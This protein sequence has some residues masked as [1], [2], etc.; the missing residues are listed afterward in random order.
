MDRRRFLY[1]S[2]GFAA[3]AAR[4]GGS[5]ILSPVAGNGG[6][7]E[8]LL[9]MYVHEGWPYNHPYAARTWTVEDW[10]G[11][12]DGLSKLGYNMVVMWPALE[13]MPEPLMPSDRAQIEKTANVIG[14][15]RRDFG[16]RVFLTLC[17]N[18]IANERVARR[19]S[20][21]RRPLFSSVEFVDPSNV[22][23]MKRMIAWRE[24]LLRP[25]SQMDGIAIIDSDPGGFPGS[26][27]S[28]FAS[29]LEQHRHMLDRLRP[30]ID[31][32]YWMHVGWEAYCDYY[33]TGR[34]RWGTPLEAE[35]VLKKIKSYDPQPW[36]I[37]IHTLNP[38]PNGTDLNLAKR[39]GLATTA[40]AFNYGAIEGE[41]E[42]PLTNFGG[43]A[44]FKAGEARAPLGVVGN[45]QT[46]CVQL[47]NTFA[48][49]RGAK[50]HPISAHDYVQFADGLIEGKAG[51]VVSAWRAIEGSDSKQM[52]VIAADLD[53]IRDAAL[54]PGNLSGLLFGNPH[55]FLSDL[56]FQ[57]RMKA[58]FVDFVGASQETIDYEKFRLFVAATAAWQKRNGFQ[59]AW[60]SIWS[61][62]WKGLAETLKKL[63][64]PSLDRILA[65]SSPDNGNWNITSYVAP[66][67]TPFERVQNLYHEWDTNGF[68]LIAEM[69]KIS[70]RTGPR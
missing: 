46:H 6:T 55:R 52:R 40:L 30:G 66:G 60:P 8:G 61:E 14:V 12:A 38:P 35:D 13:I 25:L 1:L 26:T 56:G 7:A 51:L 68:R 17:P 20:F 33:A 27:N 44:A 21:E 10:R 45:A 59:A 49:A 11:Y 18:L 42:F 37:T 58:A 31:L 62:K 43:D 41:P 29:L 2:G 39:F 47:P 32:Y 24:Q 3:L 19:Y 4:A 63:K 9:G 65:E 48:F 16:F 34:F 53:A 57:L 50:G 23:A 5:S 36:G 22:A 54:R 69:Q 67:S 15:L 28:Q 70:Q 64:S